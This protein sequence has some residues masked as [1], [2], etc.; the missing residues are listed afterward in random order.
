MDHLTKEQQDLI[1]KCIIGFICTFFF[2]V[3]MANIMLEI[4]WR[5]EGNPPHTMIGGYGQVK[6]VK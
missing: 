1:G 2:V 3:F 5:A 4:K 6:E